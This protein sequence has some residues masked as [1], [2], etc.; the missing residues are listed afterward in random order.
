MRRSS[1]INEPIEPASLALK[2]EIEY[3][4]HHPRETNHVIK[5][6]NLQNSLNPPSML[7]QRSS[8]INK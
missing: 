6:E 4:M 7:L 5:K 2:H 1:Y 3:I 8:F